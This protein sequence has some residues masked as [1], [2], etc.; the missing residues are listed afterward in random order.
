MHHWGA[1]NVLNMLFVK[2]KLNILLQPDIGQIPASLWVFYKLNTNCRKPA[3]ELITPLVSSGLLVE[4]CPEC[5]VC[6]RR[7]FINNH[8]LRLFVQRMTLLK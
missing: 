2:R 3:Y 4:V 5:P 7:I 8:F 1:Q 6:S